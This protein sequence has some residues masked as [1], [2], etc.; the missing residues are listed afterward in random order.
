MFIVIYL[1]VCFKMQC[2]LFAIFLHVCICNVGLERGSWTPHSWLKWMLIV[3]SHVAVP[4]C[5][6]LLAVIHLELVSVFKA[7]K[8]QLVLSS[9]FSPHLNKLLHTGFAA[10]QCF[11]SVDIRWHFERTVL[12]F[13]RCLMYFFFLKSYDRLV[14][15]ILMKWQL[16]KYK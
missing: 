5:Y 12:P 9:G 3:Q 15:L 7:W 4:F 13:F 1:T 11:P 2:F 10:V 14:Y 6:W 16:S 8:Y